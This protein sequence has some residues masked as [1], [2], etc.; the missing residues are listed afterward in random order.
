MKNVLGDFGNF[1]EK[2]GKATKLKKR[3]FLLQ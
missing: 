2:C 3:V 1:W